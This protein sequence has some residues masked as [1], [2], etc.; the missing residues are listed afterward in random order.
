[1]NT[2]RYYILKGNLWYKIK[3][4]YDKEKKEK[5]KLLLQNILVKGK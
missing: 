4:N 2:Y 5:T 1:M 3:I